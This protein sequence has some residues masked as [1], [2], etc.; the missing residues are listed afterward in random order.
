MVET[1][2]YHLMIEKYSILF[3]VQASLAN[4]SHI[5]P[6]CLVPILALPLGFTIFL[7]SI[8]QDTFR[9]P[10]TSPHGEQGMYTCCASVASPL[11]SR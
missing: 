4:V 5:P 9:Q 11:S 2:F 1:K 8:S 3:P 7:L 6:P 10:F